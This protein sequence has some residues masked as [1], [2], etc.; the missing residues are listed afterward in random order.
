LISVL[1]THA[2]IVVVESVSLETST[3][4]QQDPLSTTVRQAPEQEMEA[5]RSIES[6]S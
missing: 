4:N 3:A 2:P 6:G 5:P 1:G